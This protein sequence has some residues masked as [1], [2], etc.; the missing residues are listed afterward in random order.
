MKKLRVAVLFGGRSG[1]HDV[2]LM[3]TRSVLAALD[4]EKYEVTQ[5]G[6][7]LDGEWLTGANT[8]DAFTS[9][10]FSELNRAILP[11]DPSHSN[12]YQLQVTDR[13]ETIHKLSEIDVF[14]PVLHGP[15]GEDGT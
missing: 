10:K 13:V 12:I 11:G 7:T 9:G 1:E 2:S 5:I 8:L 3:S 6:I 4:P 14:F 15:F